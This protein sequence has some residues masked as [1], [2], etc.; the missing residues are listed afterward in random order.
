[1]FPASAVDL[2]NS[3]SGLDF[4][5]LPDHSRFET[6]RTVKI[7]GNVHFCKTHVLQV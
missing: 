1:M 2:I 5:S 7:D 6:D 4:K 3:L